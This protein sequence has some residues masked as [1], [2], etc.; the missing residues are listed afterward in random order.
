VSPTGPGDAFSGALAWAL[1]LGMDEYEAL[2]AASAAGALATQAMGART[3]LPSLTELTSYM[4]RHAQA[5]QT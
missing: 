1:A 4:A 2:R 3:A 5:T